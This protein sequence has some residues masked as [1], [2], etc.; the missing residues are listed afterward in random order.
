MP[1]IATLTSGAAIYVYADDHAPPHFHVRGRESN[2]QVRIDTL[3]VMAG[4]I[5]RGDRT[6]A[7][8]YGAD[9]RE[10]LLAKWREF[11]ER[12]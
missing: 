10:L 1:R 7:M 12:D 5:T 3:E 2:A 9:N 11:N 6:E 8:A 4:V